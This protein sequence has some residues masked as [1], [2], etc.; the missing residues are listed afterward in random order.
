[1]ATAVI[2]NA[3]YA[4]NTNFRSNWT[5]KNSQES[6]FELQYGINDGNNQSFWFYPQALG[7]RWGYAPSLNLF[8]AF[9]AGDARRDASIQ[10]AGAGA[11]PAAPCRYGF[12]YHRVATS[13]DNVPVIRLAEMYL[14][15]AEANARLGAA[16][17]TVRDDL[18]ILR[19]RAGLADLAVT[20]TGP[21]LLA[22]VLQERRV[23][24]AFEGHRFFDL[25]RFGVATT[26]LSIAADRQLFPIPQAERDVNINLAQNPG[27]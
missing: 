26:V 15:R 23:E 24:L 8:N 11:C 19:N 6:I 12:K 7:G 1:M 21:A 16:D 14:I 17:Q 10:V 9:E 27:Y 2:G 18:D 13:D 4:L 20:V 5:S 3:E 22:A 25:R